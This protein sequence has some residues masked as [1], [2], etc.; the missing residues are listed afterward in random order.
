M[1]ACMYI[2]HVN[3]SQCSQGSSS[4]EECFFTDTGTNTNTNATTKTNTKT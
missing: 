3:S 4:P 1:Y 2:H